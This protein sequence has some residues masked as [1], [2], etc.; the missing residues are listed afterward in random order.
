MTIQKSKN[1]YSYLFV[2]VKCL[3]YSRHV[4]STQ[5]EQIHIHKVVAEQVEEDDLVAYK[6]PLRRYC[7]K[8]H[9][10]DDE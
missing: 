10:T 4:Q 5:E 2:L 6:I 9:N 1:H 8:I 7:S 3:L